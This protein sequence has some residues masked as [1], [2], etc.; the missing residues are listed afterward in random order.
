MNWLKSFRELLFITC[1]RALLLVMPVRPQ[2]SHFKFINGEAARPSPPSDD[3]DP[4]RLLG[5]RAPFVKVMDVEWTLRG[6]P[7]ILMPGGGTPGP[8]GSW[9]IDLDVKTRPPPGWRTTCGGGCT[10]WRG[11][12]I[13]GRWTWGSAGAV[14]PTVGNGSCWW[15][16]N[17]WIILWTI[18]FP[19][20]SCKDRKEWN[21][22]I[23]VQTSKKS[24]G[25]RIREM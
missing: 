25:Q 10:C 2:I 19:P 4:S 15:W 16:S 23:F 24:F 17:W 22:Q 1:W 14:D 12:C 9:W 3:S 20:F 13:G 21:L 6:M 7:T 11:S 8:W 5:A 18:D